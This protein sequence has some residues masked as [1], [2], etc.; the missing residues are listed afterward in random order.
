MESKCEHEWNEPRLSNNS[1]LH[2]ERQCLKCGCSHKSF[3]AEK[4][5]WTLA[6]FKQQ[7]ARDHFE[8][9]GE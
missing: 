7:L 1:D 6:R 8:G 4:E 2:F 5:Y 3:M 9:K